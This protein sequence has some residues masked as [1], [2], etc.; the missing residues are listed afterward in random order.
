MPVDIERVCDRMDKAVPVSVNVSGDSALPVVILVLV[1][2][3][4]AGQALQHAGI[5]FDGSL[6]LYI[7]AWP[8]R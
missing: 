3:Q 6:R 7:C 8:H 2:E 1:L 5:V 4:V